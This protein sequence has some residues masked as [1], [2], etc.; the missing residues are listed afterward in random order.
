MPSR[1]RLQQR[2][3]AHTGC[4][5]PAKILLLSRTDL[6]ASVDLLVDPA[7]IW[8]AMLSALQ[9]GILRAEI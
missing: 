9:A 1:R 3:E 6:D 8:L 4:T 2:R 7:W 5:T